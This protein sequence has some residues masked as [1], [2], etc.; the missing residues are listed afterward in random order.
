MASLT[1]LTVGYWVVALASLSSALSHLHRCRAAVRLGTPADCCAA[2]VSGCRCR[3]CT[4][5]LAD[6]CCM[7]RLLLH[8]TLCAHLSQRVQSARM[9]LLW[10]RLGQLEG[11]QKAKPAGRQA[12]AGLDVVCWPFCC[13]W[14]LR[15]VSD[16]SKC[17]IMLLL[18][19]R[20]SLSCCNRALTLRCCV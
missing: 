9:Q 20:R 4:S 3:S 8:P 18:Q 11:N 17:T 6:E 16:S 15:I 1:V 13:T 7:V 2:D 14:S 19:A 10:V 12:E 5:N